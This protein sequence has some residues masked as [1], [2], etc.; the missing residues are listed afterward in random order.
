M[1]VEVIGLGYIGLPMACLLADA[2]HEVVGVDIDEEKVELLRSGELPFDEPGLPELFERVKDRMRFVTK[3]EPADAFIVAVPTPFDPETKASDL[4]YVKSAVESIVPVLEDGNLVVIE[5]T[6]TPGTTDGLV[7]KILNRSGRKYYLAHAPER[8]IPGKTLYEMVHN[9]RV[10]GGI[11]AESTKRAVDLYRTFVKGQI[12]ET[13]ATTAELVKLMENTY[14]DVNIALANEF[15]LIAEE[16]GV[17]VWEAIELANHHPRVNIHRPG[18]GVGGHCI[19]VDPWFLTE[20][21]HHARMIYLAREIND[22]MPKHVLSLLKRAGI[23]SGTVAVLGVA[24]KGNVDDTRET[25]AL[26]FIKLA[27]NA[28]LNVKV[29]DPHVKEFEYPLLPLKDAVRDAD[30]IVVITNH[31]VFRKID[32]KKL[33]PLV[34]RKIVIDTRNI[35][36]REKWEQA[37]FKYVRLGDGYTIRDA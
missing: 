3:P 13:D 16:L 32:P 12:L 4:R 1:K 29:H 30:A 2:G 5:S 27:E 11:N 21:T 18:P 28:G 24:Y 35:L 20:V 19:S 15:A 22:S 26:K 31:D 9:D 34:R 36:N 33:A 23:T 7:R 14:R 37:G 6:V 8:A 17:N 10:I 25:P